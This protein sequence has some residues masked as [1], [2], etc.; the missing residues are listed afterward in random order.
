MIKFTNSA[1]AQISVYGPISC[2]TDLYRPVVLT[3]KDDNTVGETIGGGNPTGYYGNGL[4][5]CTSGQALS[6]LRFAFADKGLTLDYAGGTLSLTN[7]QFVNCQTACQHEEATL[8]VRNGLIH[9]VRYVTGGYSVSFRG[10]HLT[11]HQCGRFLVDGELYLTNSLVSALTNGWGSGIV[12]TNQVVFST[13]EIAN[14]FTEVGAGYH[15]LA[16]DSP[17]R[18]CGT[19]NINSG[20]AAQLELTTT[21][22]PVELSGLVTAPTRLYGRAWGDIDQPDLGYHYAPIDYAVCT[23]TVT[24][25]GSLTLGPGLAVATYG[26]HALRLENYGSL[27]A[28]GVPKAPVRLFRYNVV[29]EQPIDWGNTAYEPTIL[30]GPCHDTLGGDAPPVASLRFVEFSGLGGYGNHLYTGNGW[31]LLKQLSLQDCTLW[32]GK[33]QFSGNS[34]SIIGLTNNLFVRTANKY[35]AWPQLSAY[36]NLFWGGS[37]RFERFPTAGTWVFR[38]NA[39]DGTGLTN[40]G[41]AIVNDYNAYIGPGQCQIGGNSISNVVLSWFPYVRGPLGEFYHYWTSLVDKG[42][43]GA[44]A[45]GLYHNTVRTN[46]LKETNS[47]VDIGFH[48]VAAD[49]EGPLDTDDDGIAG[50]LEDRNGNG[51]RDAGESDYQNPV[52]IDNCRLDGEIQAAPPE[53]L[54]ASYQCEAVLDYDTVPRNGELPDKKFLIEWETDKQSRAQQMAMFV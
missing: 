12:V 53:L 31:F 20:L 7:V 4:R 26:D 49:E 22:P 24:N 2:K 45:A 8:Q 52:S 18:D 13:S 48:Y 28:E 42:S 33:A 43:R 46:Q 50:Y 51:V 15:Y 29:Q 34:L 41:A 14:L 35:Y 37:N 6:N 19:T 39:F 47:V 32:G 27:V 3:C 9:R 11:V 17:Y 30:T 36:N 1:S 5:V 10:E 38:D 25:Y 23:L 54:F 21:Y 44:D 16:K 40:V